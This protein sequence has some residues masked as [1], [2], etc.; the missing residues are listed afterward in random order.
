MR[1]L[2]L[3]LILLSFLKPLNES[4]LTSPILLLF[5]DNNIKRHFNGQSDGRDV[6]LFSCQRKRDICWAPQNAPI[7]IRSMP[8]P[9]RLSSYKV[10]QTCIE[11]IEYDITIVWLFGLCEC[12]HLVYF[13]RQMEISPFF[14]LLNH[15][16]CF[17]VCRFTTHYS[18]VVM[19]V[20]PS[21][22]PASRLFTQPCVHAYIKDNIKA[23]HHCTSFVW[24][25]H[26]LP[27]VS[28]HKGQ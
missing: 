8:I 6:N 18:D 9:E 5:K 25:F 14:A 21:Q 27:M 16:I 4:L 13:Q 19:S 24:G 10:M 3:R 26:R 28:P 2:E 17:M 22:S 15:V 12:V 7:S 20:M 11:Y 1:L 23:P